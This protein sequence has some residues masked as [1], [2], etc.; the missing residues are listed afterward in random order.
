MTS[1][2]YKMGYRSGKA[3]AKRHTY[4]GGSVAGPENFMIRCTDAITQSGNEVDLMKLLKMEKTDKNA[5]ISYRQGI[6]NGI[7]SVMEHE[8]KVKLPKAFIEGFR[9]SMTRYR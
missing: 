7:K 9:K 4:Q 2:A 8:L 3:S 6:F 1:E 5:F